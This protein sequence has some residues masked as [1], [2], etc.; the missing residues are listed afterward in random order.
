[1]YVL[2][3]GVM[4]WISWLRWEPL[5]ILAANMWNHG[6]CSYNMAFTWDLLK[7]I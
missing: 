3:S 2:N 5:R 6:P 4:S 7:G 1:M